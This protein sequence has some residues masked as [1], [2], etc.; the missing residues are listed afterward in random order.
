[1][2]S[3]EKSSNMPKEEEKLVP[4]C[5]V[6]SL[7]K[8]EIRGQVVSGISYIHHYRHRGRKNRRLLLLLRISFC[9]RSFFKICWLLPKDM[10]PHTRSH[11]FPLRGSLSSSW[12]T[13]SELKIPKKVRFWGA[14]YYCWP[15]RL[16]LLKSCFRYS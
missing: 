8:P 6:T 10:C 14:A 7:S 1:M 13:Q 16:T 2:L 11:Y 5:M 4:T 12:Y 3:F 9:H 15:Q